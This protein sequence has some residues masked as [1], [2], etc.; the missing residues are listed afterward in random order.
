MVPGYFFQGIG[1]GLPATVRT[2]AQTV[3]LLLLAVLMMPRL[4]GGTGL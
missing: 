1:K 2:A 3:G 4:F